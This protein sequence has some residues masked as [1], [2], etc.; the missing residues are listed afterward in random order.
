M[1]TITISL[2]NTAGDIPTYNYSIEQILNDEA[3]W[4]IDALD[5]SNDKVFVCFNSWEDADYEHE[6]TEFLIT[7]SDVDAYNYFINFTKTCSHINF[8]FFCF[9]NYEE[10]F[11][12]C[13]NL[14]EG[15]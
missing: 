15:L 11:G 10:A 5:L 9:E 14:K 8:N 13:I 12:Y 1:A 6:H 2:S 7:N 4:I 3:E